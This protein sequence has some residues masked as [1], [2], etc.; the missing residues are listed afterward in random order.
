[1]IAAFLGPGPLAL[2]KPLDVIRNGLSD[3]VIVRKSEAPAPEQFAAQELQKYLR[4]ISGVE[5]PIVDGGG[6]DEKHFSSDRLRAH[7]KN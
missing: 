3:Y 5:L 6:E 1:M 7:K 4:L 2:S